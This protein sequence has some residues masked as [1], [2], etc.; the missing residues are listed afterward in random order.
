MLWR[1]MPYSVTVCVISRW[2]WT[3]ISCSVV[4]VLLIVVV[5]FC[6]ILH[7]NQ[8][9]VVVFCWC[10][11]VI[12][13]LHFVTLLHFAACCCVSYA[14]SLQLFAFCCVLLHV[15]RQFVGSILLMF[16][17]RFFRLLFIT[18]CDISCCIVC[19]CCIWLVLRS[20]FT[21]AFC[22]ILRGSLFR[23]VAFFVCYFCISTIFC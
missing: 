19:N 2:T 4:I 7:D 23:I 11:G 3:F 18:C 6:C 17:L 22:C 13:P 15:S 9:L 5:F 1:R 12:E 14:F 16:C 10:L 20:R 21:F 8:Y